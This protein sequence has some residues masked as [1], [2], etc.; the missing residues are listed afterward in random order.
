[1]VTCPATI[2]AQDDCDTGPTS[3][4]VDSVRVNWRKRRVI[5]RVGR[6]QG[7]ADLLRRGSHQDSIRPQVILV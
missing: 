7:R 6:R 5:G 3:S 2:S 1:M 4:V